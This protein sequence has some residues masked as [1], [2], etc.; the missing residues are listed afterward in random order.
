M[1]L[2]IQ[3]LYRWVE[4]RLINRSHKMFCVSCGKV[5]KERDANLSTGLESGVEVAELVKR[6][7][8]D[9]GAWCLPGYGVPLALIL[10]K[11]GE[12]KCFVL[13]RDIFPLKDGEEGWTSLQQSVM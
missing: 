4:L 10:L 8:G 11:E 3:K 12:N 6:W 9:V 7:M 13:S 5:E 1:R 2:S